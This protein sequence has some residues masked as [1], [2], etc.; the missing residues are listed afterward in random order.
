MI[1]KEAMLLDV[2]IFFGFCYFSLKSGHSY[3]Q[4]LLELTKLVILSVNFPQLNMVLILPLC[5]EVDQMKP[6]ACFESFVSLFLFNQNLGL[7]Y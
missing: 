2:S 4:K 6:F 3:M 1:W 7:W 5:F